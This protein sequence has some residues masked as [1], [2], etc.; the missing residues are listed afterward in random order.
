MSETVN[1]YFKK[2]SDLAAELERILI[3]KKESRTATAYVGHSG[4]T[5]NKFYPTDAEEVR[6]VR[7]VLHELYDGEA[8]RLLQELRQIGTRFN[9]I[10][11]DLERRFLESKE[12]FDQEDRT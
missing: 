11:D 4:S 7:A 12:G 5:F 6:K 2:A 9:Q 3:A 10:V 1:N 8:Y